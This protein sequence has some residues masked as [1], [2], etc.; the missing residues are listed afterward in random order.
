MYYLSF[1]FLR[2]AKRIMKI[3]NALVERLAELSKLEFE[4]EEKERIKTDLQNIFNLVEKLNEVNV[5]G[6][7]PLIYMSEE[8]NVL[9][10]DVV[11]GEVPKVEALLNAPQKDSDYFK[12]PKVIKK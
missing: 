12:V 7:E 6:V 10:K 4:T 3:D 5:D 9:R 2:E 8:R 11:Q 1:L